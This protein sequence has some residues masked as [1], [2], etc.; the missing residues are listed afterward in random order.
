V[1][2]FDFLSLLFAC[3]CAFLA[4]ADLR[5]DINKQK[6]QRTTNKQKTKS[7][8]QKAK[9]RNQKKKSGKQKAKPSRLESCL[10][11]GFLPA[12]WPLDRLI[13]L[14]LTQSVV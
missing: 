11:I 5:N 12:L 3:F 6:E 14:L 8:N 7:R 13:G 4:F 2:F 1:C 10:Q 9:I